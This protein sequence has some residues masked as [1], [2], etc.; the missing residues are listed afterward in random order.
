MILTVHRGTHEIGGTSIEIESDN[1]RILLDFGLPLVDQNREPFD[2]AKI[3]GKSKDRLIK[4]GILPDIKG[5]YQDE[6]PKI[7]G[8][9]LSHP[10]QD[11]YGLLSYVDP[12]IPVYM[13][14]GCKLLIDASHYFSQT[15]CQLNNTR[16]LEAWK[17]FQIG[18]F[19]IS[20]Y[21]MDHSGFDALAFLVQS[22]KKKIFY[23]GDFR[24][25]GRKSVTYTNLL[26]HPPK[27]VDYLI[28]EGSMIGR[29]YETETDVEK[30]MTAL[31]KTDGL[32]F[33]ACSSQNI[34]RLVT[35]YRACKKTGRTF[36]ID[37]YTAYILNQAKTVSPRIPQSDWGEN[38]RI[39]FVPNS[40]TKRMADDKTLFNFKNSKITYAQIHNSKES[41]VIKDNLLVRKTFKNNQDLTGATLIFSLWEGYLPDIEPFWR[42]NNVPILRIH[43]S[44]HAYITELKQLINAIKPKTIIP[45]HTFHAEDFKNLF[46]TR[47]IVL[48]DGQRLTL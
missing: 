6:Q 35:I 12:K 18:D 48:K 8:I 19:E 42:T 38:M 46:K 5:L 31:F 9:L 1:S 27:N 23:T 22:D 3:K 37:P 45:N 10:H 28:I 17:T 34:D 24:G 16:I 30:A 4:L 26:K 39:Y 32:Y 43:T 21:L 7:A 47:T 13:S 20:P 29:R 14:K 41:L 25:H 44:G 33:I 40:Y 2:A 36:I 15:P 11:H